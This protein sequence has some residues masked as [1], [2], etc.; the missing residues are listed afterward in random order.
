[1][2][3]PVMPTY[4]RAPIVVERGEGC[5][6]IDDRGRRFSISGRGSR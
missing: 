2:I 1:M 3:D 6:L 5:W 4:A